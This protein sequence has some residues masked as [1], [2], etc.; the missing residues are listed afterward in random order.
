MSCRGT[1]AKAK[2]KRLRDLRHLSCHSARARVSRR[3]VG[4]PAHGI[5]PLHRRHSTS[6]SSISARTTMRLHVPLPR[7]LAEARQR[8]T[9]ESVGSFTS[10][11][12]LYMRSFNGF[13]NQKSAMST[14]HVFTSSSAPPLKDIITGMARHGMSTFYKFGRYPDTLSTTF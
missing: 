11:N 10:H 8:T 6:L 2:E 4:R 9:S 1:R 5:S 3:P 7:P 12:Q 13:P 14:S